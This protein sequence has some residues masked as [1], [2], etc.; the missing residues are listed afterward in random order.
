[1]RE[2]AL[3]FLLL[4]SL[5]LFG[6]QAT[7]TSFPQDWQLFPRDLSTNQAIINV[8]GQ[9]TDSGNSAIFLEV[10]RDGQFLINLVLNLT[11]SA[12][13]PF[14]FNFNLPAELHQYG[15][16]LIISRG[17]QSTVVHQTQN[18]VAGDVF[19]IQGQSNAYADNYG[20]G[21]AEPNNQWIRSFGTTTLDPNTVLS[22]SSWH[23][24]TAIA[25]HQGRIGIWGVKLGEML[26]AANQVPVAILNGAVGGSSIS[27]HQYDTNTNSL[28]GQLLYR[29]QQAGVTDNVR[30]IIWWQGERDA[31]GDLVQTQQQY[32]DQFVTLRNA[33]HL[34][35]PA[36]EQ[37]YLTQIHT[38]LNEPIAHQIR[39]AQRLLALNLQD[40]RIQT[41][42]NLGHFDNF[43]HHEPL[44]YQLYAQ[45]IFRQIMDDLY[46][47]TNTEIDPP[48]LLTA[49]YNGLK[50][51]IDLEFD[52][53]ILWQSPYTI[54]GAGVQNLK[55]YFYIDG[56]NIPVDSFAVIANHLFLF[57]QQ[58]LSAQS[59]TYLPASKYT[60]TN[61][62]YRGPWLTNSQGLGVV[63]WHNFPILKPA[64]PIEL[65]VFLQGS[66]SDSLNQM[67]SSLNLPRKVLPGQSNSNVVSLQPYGVL[68]WNYQGVEGQGFTNLTY[69]DEVVDWVLVSLR[70]DTAATTTLY[71]VAGL[72]DTDGRFRFVAP[73]FISFNPQDSFFIVVEHRNHMALMSASRVKVTNGSLT[74]DFTMQD[75]YNS[76]GKSYG[77]TEVAPGIWAMIAGD[78]D[79]R[80]DSVS[81]DINGR[82]KQLWLNDNG[83]F[84]GYFSADYNMSGEVTGADRILWRLNNGFSSRV[85]R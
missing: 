54:T 2:T 56:V 34:D 53:P 82:D 16:S 67:H 80:L 78:G 6:Q 75:S 37:I 44:G 15:F 19:V 74:H 24:A 72:L 76:N 31:L 65:K 25:A 61:I 12:N 62:V 32:Y 66:Y 10:T 43:S 40:V 85:P 39:E 3:L 23:Q 49:T 45:R 84:S 79:Q 57:F 68:P 18:V 46:G 11:G 33:W 51:S 63:S 38:V 13:Q 69:N 20:G 50:T 26:A 4:T 64:F 17:G 27:I 22:D 59:L 8:T 29:A 58:S 21:Y 77:A 14:S 55:D 60:N 5:L 9:V 83:T 47:A 81:Y 28:Y 36:L 70:T 7:V 35:F 1:M 71:R 73:P 42:F 52:Q 41:P 48:Q 30:A